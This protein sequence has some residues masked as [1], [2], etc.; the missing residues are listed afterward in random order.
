MQDKVPETAVAI[1]AADPLVAWSKVAALFHPLPPVQP[2]HPPSAVVA[3]S[4]RIDPT[5]EI[6]PLAVIGENVVDRPAR[7]DR[8]HG[9]DR[10]RRRDRP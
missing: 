4:A 2:R 1:V 3:A 5:A 8:R 9:G 7:A 10:R 6:G